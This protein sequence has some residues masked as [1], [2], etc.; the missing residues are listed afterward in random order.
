MWWPLGALALGLQ[1]ESRSSRRL[2]ENE[3]LCPWPLD[4]PGLAGL[5]RGERSAEGQFRAVVQHHTDAFLLD[6]Y[7][8]RLG[9]NAYGL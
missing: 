9:S 7:D 5:I 3:I 4:H 1:A 8:H 2:A 6:V